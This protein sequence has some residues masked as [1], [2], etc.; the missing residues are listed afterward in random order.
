ME[1][2]AIVQAETALHVSVSLD[3][4]VSVSTQVA[5]LRRL[6]Y[7]SDEGAWKRVREV[8]RGVLLLCLVLMFFS[9]AVGPDSFGGEC[10]ERGYHGDAA[11]SQVGFRVFERAEDFYD[12]CGGFGGAPTC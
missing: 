9:L 4:G 6:L 5:A 8:C 10:G 2:G 12:F 1:R 7:E 3:L 11:S